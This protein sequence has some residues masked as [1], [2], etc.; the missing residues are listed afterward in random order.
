MWHTQGSGKSILIVLLAKWILEN[1]PHA[2]V[3][4]ITDRDELDKQ[5]EGVFGE[6]GEEMWRSSSGRDLLAQLA[7]VKPRLLCLLIHKF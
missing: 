4:V 5:I 3:V 1:N 6:A 7:Q 2:R